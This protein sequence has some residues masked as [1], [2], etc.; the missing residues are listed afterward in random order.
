MRIPDVIRVSLPE[1]AGAAEDIGRSG[2]TVLDYGDRFLK[3]Q[4][5]CNVS[6]NEYFMLRWMQGRIPVPRILAAAQADSRRWLVTSRMPGQYL[7]TEALLDDQHRL[8]EICAQALRTLWSVD[9]STCPTRRT[10]DDKL[11]EIEAG[12]RG[13]WI[14]REQAGDPTIYDVSAGGFASPAALFDWLLKHR[15]EEELALSHGD[16]CLPNIFADGQG[17]TGF[18]DVGLAGVAD[19]WVDIEKCLWSM[20]ANTTGFF[21]GRAR[22]FDRQLLFDSLDMQPDEEKLRYYG[23][24][25]ALC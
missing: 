8:A 11:C 10:L 25:D 3:V 9:I 16:L 21:G 5:E 17:L 23:L 4:E 24:L 12:L 15:P 13:G 6:A 7:C 18:I 19:K 2:A 20:W 1:M 14:T 22:P